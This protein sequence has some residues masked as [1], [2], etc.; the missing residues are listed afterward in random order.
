M[1]ILHPGRYLENL[2]GSESGQ[3]ITGKQVPDDGCLAHIVACHQT[4]GTA[5]AHIVDGEQDD[6]LRVAIEAALKA[7]GV[8]MK[9][10]DT[11]ALS[12]EED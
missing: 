8:M 10:N 12:K 11:S 4:T 3:F 5:L 2:V 6:R 9:T 1:S 7:Q